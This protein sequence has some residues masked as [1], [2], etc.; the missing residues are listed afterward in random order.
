M[1]QL[2]F[3][4]EVSNDLK[5]AVNNDQIVKHYFNDYPVKMR[6]TVKLN[7]EFLAK[8][9]GT[10]FLEEVQ[11]IKE[12]MD[13]EIKEN[14]PFLIDSIILN[15]LAFE[16]NENLQKTVYKDY[17]NKSI[18]KHAKGFIAGQ[19]QI[20]RDHH[21]KLLLKTEQETQKVLQETM[22]IIELVRSRG[23]HSL[24]EVENILKAH[25]KDPKS[26]NGIVNKVLKR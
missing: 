19:F 2:T 22:N 26:I 18:K 4:T 14:L 3:Q 6:K 8:K 5:D 25:Q 13:K 23:L 15:T 9:N 7:A 17:H 10:T 1:K 12:H 11:G 16:A 20:Y 21:E 24:I